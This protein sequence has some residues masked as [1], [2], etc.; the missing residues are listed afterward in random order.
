MVLLGQ[1]GDMHMSI[2]RVA[3]VK[4]QLPFQISISSFHF[5]FP[6]H[7]HFLLF[8]IPPSVV[9]T[10][11]EFFVCTR[12]STSMHTHAHISVSGEDSR[13]PLRHLATL[14]S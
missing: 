7:F 12:V 8:H 5:Q 9:K 10:E 11:S 6:F 13:S 2:F 14:G 1:R 3:N 4:N